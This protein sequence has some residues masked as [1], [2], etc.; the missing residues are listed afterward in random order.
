MSVHLWET[1]TGK[2]L[3]QTLYP[4]GHGAIA[5]LSADGK[6][7]LTGSSLKTA[8]LWETATGKPR[9]LE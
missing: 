4:K 6:T 7:V 2:P 3:G 9:R 5:A 1:A 8:R